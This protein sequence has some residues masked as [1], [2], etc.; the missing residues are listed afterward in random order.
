M[1][2]STV[3]GH[4]LSH[5]ALHAVLY[6]SILYRAGCSV[7]LGTFVFKVS[8]SLALQENDLLHR[9]PPSSS[10]FWLLLFSSVSFHGQAVEVELKRVRAVGVAG[11]GGVAGLVLGEW[12]RDIAATQYTRFLQAAWPV[13]PLWAL[14]LGASQLVTL[15]IEEYRTHKRLIRGLR[16]GQQR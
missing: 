12:G 10:C 5:T 4:V 2:R 8:F 1:Y 7:T 6:C 14:L 16:R 15:P 9:S 11:W 3:H 13:S